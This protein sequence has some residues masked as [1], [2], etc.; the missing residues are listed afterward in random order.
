MIDFRRFIVLPVVAVLVL[1][2]L[3]TSC[4]SRVDD[5]YFTQQEVGVINS[6]ADDSLMR[7]LFTTVEEDSLFLRQN[8][9]PITDEMLGS[10][11]FSLL[12]RRMLL[13]VKDPNNE[14]VGIAAPQVGISRKL[15][16]VQRFDK[17]GEPFEFY[18][19]PE[20]I[21]YGETVDTGMEGCLSIP[22][23]VGNVVRPQEI[24]IRYRTL[25]AEDTVETVS[26]FTAVIFQHEIDHLYGIL[27]TDRADSVFVA[28]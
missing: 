11:D 19:N 7:V 4:S 2:V 5:R 21:R 28:E 20:I 26:G 14:G 25:S 23:L 12:C 27:Y 15:V 22:N 1:S 6:F 16:A 13:T 8:A 9:L 10:E 24:D 17:A 3:M 18:V